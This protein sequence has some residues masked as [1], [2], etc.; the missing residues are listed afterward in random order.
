[1]AT[2]QPA[3]AKV[4]ANVSVTHCRKAAKGDPITRNGVRASSTANAEFHAKTSGT[5]LL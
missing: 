3:T 4:I 2:S 5:G 1:M